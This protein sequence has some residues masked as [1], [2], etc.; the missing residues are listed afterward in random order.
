MDAGCL[1]I[2]LCDEN[3]ENFYRLLLHTEIR[4]LFKDTRLKILY[5]LFDSVVTFFEIKDDLLKT[6]LNSKTI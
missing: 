1:L 4:W 3:G 5:G 2:K 6:R